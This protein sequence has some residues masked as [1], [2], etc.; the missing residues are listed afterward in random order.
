MLSGLEVTEIKFSDI[1]LGDRFDPEY[2]SKLNLSIEKALIHKNARKLSSFGEL[3]A[4]AF[5]PAATHLYEKGEIPF[6]RCVDC[7]NYPV[8]SNM[9]DD[10]FEKIPLDFIQENSSVKTLVKNEIV[11]TKVGSPCFASI[12]YEHDFVALSRTVLGISNIHNINPFYLL[13]FLRS[14]YG[15]NQL[16]RER[17]QTIQFQLTL[18]RVRKILA[19]EPSDIFQSQVEKTVK[20]AYQKLEQ[21]KT[22][23]R[24]AETLLLRELGLDNWQPPKET[25]AIKSFSD[26]FGKT[27]RL[28]AEYYQ[29]K[30]SHAIAAL[31]QTKHRVTE[32]GALIEPV[33]NGFDFR[34][35]SE[36]GTPYIR[37]GDIKHG[38]IDIEGSVKIP[39]L[40]KDLKKSSIQL[41]IGDILFTRKGSFG[42]SAVVT[43]KE[44]HTIISS[45]IMLLRL[46]DDSVLPDYLT[47]FLNSLFGYLQIEQRVHGVAYYS[48]SQ[49]DLASIEIVIPS[50]KIQNHLVEKIQ[51]SF[52][53]RTESQRLL[54]LAKQ[55]VETAVEENEE[56]A[57]CLL[58]NH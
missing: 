8:I 57:S 23:Y 40:Q 24:E 58:K 43:E 20:T 55:A 46:I 4:S 21:S 11:I 25:V 42:N 48:I 37:V 27:G 53:L 22:L 6:I 45:E 38:R 28:D 9:Q 50:I 52:A 1:D 10:I 54:D 7:V 19:Y 47:L 13:V 34:E 2:F 14:K 39:M 56:T 30:Y 17:E 44:I 36:E 35:F 32:L 15:F 49:E 12:I 18:E 29:P 31:H 33:R 5:Y 3:V 16:L 51:K 41:K 26:S